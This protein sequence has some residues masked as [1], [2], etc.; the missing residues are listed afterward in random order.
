MS[1]GLLSCF[2]RVILF[3]FCCGFSF[4]FLRWGL[5]DFFCRV[6]VRGFFILD[7]FLFWKVG[8]GRS[9]YLFVGFYCSLERFFKLFREY[10]VNVFKIRRWV[11]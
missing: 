1:F 7:L 2:V 9:L 3:V 11:L 4:S 10:F 8:R 5:V 6:E